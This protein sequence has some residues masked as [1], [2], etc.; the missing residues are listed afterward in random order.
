MVRQRE[1]PRSKTEF[2]R[3]LA[4]AG[5]SDFLVLDKETA[6]QVLTARRL[7]LLEYLR[8]NEAESVTGLA[9]ALGRDKAAVSRDLDLLWEHSLV[10]YERDGRRKIPSVWHETVLIEPIL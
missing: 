8:D 4:E 5:L 2:V 9:D 10:D 1:R 6:D 7:E 3:L